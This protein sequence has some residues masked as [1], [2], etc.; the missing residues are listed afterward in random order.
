MCLDELEKNGTD[1]RA[2]DEELRSIMLMMT[3]CETASGKVSEIVAAM[4][5]C[6]D[7]LAVDVTNIPKQDPQKQEEELWQCCSRAGISPELFD[8]MRTLGPKGV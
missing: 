4:G 7:R 3:K 5:K 2:F 1:R 6:L 8:A